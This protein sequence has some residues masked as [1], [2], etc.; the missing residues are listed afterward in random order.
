MQPGIDI[1]MYI[2]SIS[3]IHGFIRKSS[4]IKWIGYFDEVIYSWREWQL[5]YYY[6]YIDIV[7]Y[8][9]KYEKPSSIFWTV[10]SGKTP[11]PAVPIAHTKCSIASN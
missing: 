5:L 10:S 3:H 2:T 4:S 1:K 8:L 7:S 11:Y 9:G 6:Y